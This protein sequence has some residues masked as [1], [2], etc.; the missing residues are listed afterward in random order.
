[1]LNFLVARLKRVKQKQWRLIVITYFI[2]L[3][4]VSPKHDPFKNVLEKEEGKLTWEIF[5]FFF[6]FFTPSL[7]S[8]VQ[9][10]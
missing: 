8:L 6:S 3:N 7:C 1:M 5:T 9:I 2:L 10:L 4:S